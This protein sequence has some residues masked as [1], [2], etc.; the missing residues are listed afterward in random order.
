M[1]LMFYIG[2]SLLLTTHPYFDTRFNSTFTFI[3]VYQ[4]IKPEPPI[5]AF[6]RFK[7]LP[8]TQIG[9]QDLMIILKFP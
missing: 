9:S 5:V 2:F 6:L 3:Q 1:I 8:I 7:K 4:N